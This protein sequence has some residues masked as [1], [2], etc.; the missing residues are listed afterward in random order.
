MKRSPLKRKTP[1]RRMSKRRQSE[2]NEYEKLK[3]QFLKEH[4][5]CQL[6]MAE[7]NIREGDWGDRVKAFCMGAPRSTEIHH[8][9]CGSNRKKHFLDVSSWMALS[10]QSHEKI[11]QNPKWARENG[12]LY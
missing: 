10:R 4:D 9:F 1:L 11:H 7:N 8:K 6:W 12:Y 3:E 5:I 2:S